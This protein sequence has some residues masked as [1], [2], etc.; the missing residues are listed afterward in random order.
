MSPVAAN[1][2]S[3]AEYAAA[4]MLPIVSGIALAGPDR[5]ALVRAVKV[6]SCLNLLIHTPSLARWSEEWLPWFLVGT[7]DHLEHHKR[8]TTL[9][10]APTFCVDRIVARLGGAGAPERGARKAQ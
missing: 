3:L 2:V 9:Y 10:A 1:C 8:L 7:H 5:L 4:Y 6:I